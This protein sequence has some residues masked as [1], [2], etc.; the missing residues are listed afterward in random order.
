MTE[1]DP[2]IKTDR[3]V[4]GPAPRPDF[5]RRIFILAALVGVVIT[6]ELLAATAWFIATGRAFSYHRAV[7]AQELAMQGPFGEALPEGAETKRGVLGPLALHP[8]LG[9]V[10]DPSL[11]GKRFRKNHGFGI[12]NYGFIDEEDPIHKRSPDRLIVAV[13]GGSV[14]YY[15][16]VDGEEDLRS[17]LGTVAEGREITIVRMALGGWKQPQQLLA[18]TWLLSLGAEFDVV[19]NIDGFNE[20]A[21]PW[22]ENAQDGVFPGF[23]RLWPIQIRGVPSN[24]EKRLMADALVASGSREDWARSFLDT[25]A[26]YSVAAQTIWK[27]RDMALVSNMARTFQALQDWK[28]EGLPYAAVGPGISESTTEDDL[29][30]VLAADWRR[31]SLQLS[32]LCAANGIRYFHFLQANQYVPGSKPMSEAERREVVNPDHPY[33]RGAIMG[34]P[35]LIAEGQSLREAGVDFHDLT[36]LFVDEEEPM[37]SDDCCHYTE[38]GNRRVMRRVAE[39]VVASIK[40]REL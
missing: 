31:S 4:S 17:A 12:N 35:F 37:Y 20:V 3:S 22:P 24:P 32:R 9:F 1:P 18:V 38:E 34:Y 39:A 27:F 25:P 16:S 28:P 36:M 6:I 26:R 29:Y 10:Y 23:P 14:A 8:Y 11:Q 15:T 13:I 2:A 30:P 7:A 5:K 40:A 19:I 33:R 21:L